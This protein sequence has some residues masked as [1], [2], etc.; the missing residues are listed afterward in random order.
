MRQYLLIVVNYGR[1]FT[2]HQL[3]SNMVAT[4]G[5]MLQGRVGI[6]YE[7]LIEIDYPPLPQYSSQL[8]LNDERT[9]TSITSHQSIA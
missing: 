7:Y 9:A 2:K 3:A 6:Y 1:R 5:A 4:D 8:G